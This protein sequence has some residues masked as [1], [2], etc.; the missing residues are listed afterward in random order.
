VYRLVAYGTLPIGAIAG[1]V[2]AHLA[3]LNTPFLAGGAVLIVT[4]ALL[5]P[6]LPN[7]QPVDETP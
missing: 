6:R 4:A 2:L 7:P 5:A 3:G 1:G